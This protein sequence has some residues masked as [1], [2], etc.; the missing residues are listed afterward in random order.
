M[1]S[2]D[3]PEDGRHFEVHLTR[4]VFLSRALTVTSYEVRL[5]EQ[6]TRGLARELANALLD[7]VLAQTAPAQ[8]QLLSPDQDPQQWILRMAQK[9]A[10][11][12][13]T[14]GVQATYLDPKGEVVGLLGLSFPE[15]VD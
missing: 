8:L 4:R 7:A 9:G 6:K 10:V 11:D 13:M 15:D 5:P 2:Q 12:E 14:L 1:S 3:L